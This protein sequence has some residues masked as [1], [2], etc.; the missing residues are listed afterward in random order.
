[1][2]GS[3]WPMTELSAGYAGTWQ[4]LSGLVAELSAD[5]QAALMGGTAEQVY[6]LRGAP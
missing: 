4:V 3:D 6:G 1:M 5:E 2:W